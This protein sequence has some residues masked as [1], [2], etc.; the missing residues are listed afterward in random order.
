MG[1]MLLKVTAWLRCRSK[2]KNVASFLGGL[3][4][5]K[6]TNVHFKDCAEFLQRGLLLC[7]WVDTKMTAFCIFKGIL[8][9]L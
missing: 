1:W 9:S 7:I 5:C 3:G 4:A 2:K 8:Q 6:A